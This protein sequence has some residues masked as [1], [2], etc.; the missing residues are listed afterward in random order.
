MSPR[1]PQ[2]NDDTQ[3]NQNS[4]GTQRPIRQTRPRTASINPQSDDE[5]SYQPSNDDNHEDNFDDTPKTVAAFRDATETID[6]L[7]YIAT[8]HPL[9]PARKSLV[10]DHPRTLN[11]FRNHPEFWWKILVAMQKQAKIN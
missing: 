2:D 5:D 4:E 3:D 6:A 9:R 1:T 11:R 7:D 8:D 10:L